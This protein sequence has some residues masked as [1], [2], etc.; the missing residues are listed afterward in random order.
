MRIA[1]GFLIMLLFSSASLA[2]DRQI[3]PVTKARCEAITLDMGVA[4]IT[5]EMVAEKANVAPLSVLLHRAYYRDI[6]GGVCYFEFDTPDGIKSCW[7]GTAE[8]ETEDVTYVDG[9]PTFPVLVKDP[10]KRP[11]LVVVSC[12]DFK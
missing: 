10:G 6:E 3:F 1:L 9:K 4:T 7:Y 12:M 8:S 5:A 2:F 11:F